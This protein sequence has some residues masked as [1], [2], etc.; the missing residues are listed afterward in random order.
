MA[1]YRRGRGSL[2]YQPEFKRDLLW[3]FWSWNRNPYIVCDL[4]GGL[5][6]KLMDGAF[7]AEGQIDPCEIVLISGSVIYHDR[8]PPC[9]TRETLI[10]EVFEP[11]DRFVREQSLECPIVEVVEGQPMTDDQFML[12]LDNQ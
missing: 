9:P 8:L 10:R 11:L 7:D 4:N 2:F 6:V 5:D 12:W 1:A 3:E